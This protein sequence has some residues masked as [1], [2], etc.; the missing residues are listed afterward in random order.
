MPLVTMV[1]RNFFWTQIHTFLHF[2]T[3]K[4]RIV[5]SIVGHCRHLNCTIKHH[6]AHGSLGSRS[7]GCLA[8]DRASLYCIGSGVRTDPLHYT[9]QPLCYTVNHALYCIAYKTP[10]YCIA[11]DP[12][13][14]CIAYMTHCYMLH[15]HYHCH[16]R[17]IG[18]CL[19]A[20][21]RDH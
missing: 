12:S 15:Y 14:Y 7:Q 6:F 20:R 10:L 17:Y 16:Y 21:A 13:I 5:A 11:Y 18:H 1:N 3:L 9:T 4:H 19:C 2:S 8:P